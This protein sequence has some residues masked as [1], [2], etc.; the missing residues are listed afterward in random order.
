MS[1]FTNKMKVIILSS[2]YGQRQHQTRKFGSSSIPPPTIKHLEVSSILIILRIPFHG[3]FAF[4]Q[5]QIYSYIHFLCIHLY[6]SCF[7]I[8]L[9]LKRRERM[10]HDRSS[11][12]NRMS[13]VKAERHCWLYSSHLQKTYLSSPRCSQSDRRNGHKRIRNGIEVFQYLQ[14]SVSSQTHVRPFLSH[15]YLEG[16]NGG[17]KAG[18]RLPS[19]PSANAVPFFTCQETCTWMSSHIAVAVR[20]SL[21]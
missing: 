5:K 12:S 7:Q 3:A 9:T 10:W 1:L 14:E 6:P 20:P 4:I 19:S 18:F 16:L 15:K 17:A 2:G 11:F 21:F 8:M 13:T